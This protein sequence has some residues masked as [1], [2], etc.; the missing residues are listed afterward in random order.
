M[1]DLQFNGSNYIGGVFKHV[2]SKTFRFQIKECPVISVI[3]YDE[4]WQPL[5]GGVIVYIH[6]ILFVNNIVLNEYAN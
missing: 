4:N 6:H 3:F 5:G 2:K 1:V